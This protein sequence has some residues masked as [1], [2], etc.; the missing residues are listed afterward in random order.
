MAHLKCSAIALI[1]LFSLCTGVAAQ[2]YEDLLVNGGFETDVNTVGPWPDDAGYWRGNYSDIVGA[3]AGITPLEGDRMLHFIYGGS[4]AYATNLTGSN[5]LQ[6]VD[7]R[8]L[9]DAVSGGH[10]VVKAEVSFNRV[11][12]DAQT[13]RRFGLAVRAFVG[14]PNT[15][16]TQWSA[17]YIA[18]ELV[19]WVSDADPGSWETV[20]LTL[21]L[22]V[23]TDFVMIHIYAAEDVYNDT[24]GVEF[25]GLFADAATLSVVSTTPGDFD[26]D[27]DVDADDVDALCDHMSQP[28]V[29]MDGDGDADEDDLTYLVENL[30]ELQDG[31]GRVGTQRGDFNLNGLVN[32]T[33]LAIMAN[34]FGTWPRGWA[35]GNANCD[36]VVD[37]TDLAILANNFGFT[38]PTGIAVPEPA[39]MGL[40]GLGGVMLL[41]RR[42]GRA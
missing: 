12:L 28:L 23:Q 5:V 35:D 41:R 15:G 22:P 3:T 16:R 27:G 14:D 21:T 19:D 31:S 8:S 32:A 38:A 1:A 6:T 39:T 17:S 13:D 24:S 11:D 34:T 10:A 25:D 26:V 30:V 9:H 29:D 7:L 18:D 2:P 37:G 36:D 4:A 40:L 20:D 33:D 42:R